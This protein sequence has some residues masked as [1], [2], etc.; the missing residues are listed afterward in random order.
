MRYTNRCLPL[1]LPY[2]K[3][4]YNLFDINIVIV[5]F[6][7]QT[8]KNTLGTHLLTVQQPTFKVKYGQ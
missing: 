6:V 4:I 2:N 5:L 7:S 3:N 8:E 1:P